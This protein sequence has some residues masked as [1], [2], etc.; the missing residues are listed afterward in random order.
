MQAK[1]PREDV[2]HNMNCCTLLGGNLLA[3]G[4]FGSDWTV[5]ETVQDVCGLASA[6]HHRAGDENSTDMSQAELDTAAGVESG[7]CIQHALPHKDYLGRRLDG[8][9][10][11]TATLGR[12]RNAYAQRL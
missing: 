9:G 3:V 7:S 6:T 4:V 8:A 1:L 5:R 2:H 10:R 11:Y 12:V